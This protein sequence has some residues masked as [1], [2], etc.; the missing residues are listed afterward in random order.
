MHDIYDELIEKIDRITSFYNLN[1]AI[2]YKE[3]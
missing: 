2:S 3:K 1:K